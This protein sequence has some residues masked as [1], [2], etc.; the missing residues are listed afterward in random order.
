[1]TQGLP[2]LRERRSAGG[3]RRFR[4]TRPTLHHADGP[5]EPHKLP[6]NAIRISYRKA[7]DFHPRVR[8]KT[9]LPLSA[10][11]LNVR[12]DSMTSEQPPEHQRSIEAVRRKRKVPFRSRLHSD[13]GAANRSE[14]SVAAVR[15]NTG[16]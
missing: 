9:A 14:R 2:A 6:V 11:D 4:S 13:D 15:A 5:V 12:R 8:L 16:R 10:P 3:F 1:V 7:L